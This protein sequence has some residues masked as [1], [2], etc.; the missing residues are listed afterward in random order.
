MKKIF[1]LLLISMPLLVSAQNLNGRFSSSFYTF[2]RFNSLNES[3]T[4]IRTFQSL[5]LNFNYGKFSIKTRTSAETNMWN[6][7]DSSSSRL[8]FYNLYLEARDV[9]DIATIK[10]GR[11]PIYNS[12]TGGL[13]DG[14]NLKLR[15]NG[16]SLSGYYGGNVPAYQKLQFTDDIEND[17]LL[18][19]TFEV[20]ALEGFRFAVSYVDKNF[21]PLN[22]TAMRLS[23]NLDPIQVLIEQKSNQ[24]KFLSGEAS[25]EMKGVFSIDAKYDYDL[26][27]NETSKVEATG[28]VQITD[29]LGANAYYNLR[30]PMIRYNSIFSVFNYGNSQEIEGGL[31]YK[32]NDFFTVTGKFGQVEYEDENSQRVTLGVNSNYG[33]FS[34]RKTMGYAGEL[35]NISIYTAHSFL[36]GKLTPSLGVAFTTYKLSKDSEENNITSILAGLNVRPWNKLSFDLQ[37]QYFNNKIYTN[38]FRVLVKINYWFNTNF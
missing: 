3:D 4:Y 7:V 6:A 32:I 24:Y 26:N 31:D 2:E 19:G 9:F 1:F 28:R 34:Y 20:T 21:K 14:A 13:F 36:E 27:F 30:E 8:R 38:D 37:G 10:L 5:N 33:S 35:D 23:E 18:G 16:F 17:Y 25:Y 11:Q 12:V 29:E 15:Y 22:Y